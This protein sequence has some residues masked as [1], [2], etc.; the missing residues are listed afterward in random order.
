MAFEFTSSTRSLN[1]KNT[2]LS[3]RVALFKHSGTMRPLFNCCRDTSWF[4]RMLFRWL[5]VPSI[6]EILAAHTPKTTINA[7]NNPKR[8]TQFEH[9]SM[10]ISLL[11]G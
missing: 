8:N 7:N 11:N 9:I 1:G 3:P 4:A 10:D 2:H 5:S 6:E